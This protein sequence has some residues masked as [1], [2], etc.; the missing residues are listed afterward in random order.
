MRQVS[1]VKG[2]EEVELLLFSVCMSTERRRKELL[3]VLDPRHRIEISAEIKTRA[4]NLHITSQHTEQKQ[5]LSHVR[6][7]DP[8]RFRSVVERG[9]RDASELC[10]CGQIFTWNI[11]NKQ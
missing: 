7:E 10:D 1:S 3:R 8:A 5:L 9:H 11:K 6:G 4:V 2:A